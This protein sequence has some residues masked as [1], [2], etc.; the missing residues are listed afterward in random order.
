MPKSKARKVLDT[1]LKS[2]KPKAKPKSKI[3]QASK[4]KNPKRYG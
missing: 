4:R 1:V 3:R 2:K